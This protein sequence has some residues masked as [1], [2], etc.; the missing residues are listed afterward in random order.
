[1]WGDGSYTIA[2]GTYSYDPSTKLIKLNGYSSYIHSVVLKAVTV[3]KACHLAKVSGSFDF[4]T[5]F[6]N[7]ADSD[8]RNHSVWF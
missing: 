6:G 8:F 1:M 2:E 7:T 5:D 4:V 3:G